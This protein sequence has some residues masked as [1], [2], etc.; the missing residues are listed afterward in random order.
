MEEQVKTFCGVCRHPSPG[1]EPGCPVETGEP[2]RGVNVWPFGINPQDMQP[3]GQVQGQ[4][5]QMGGGPGLA[6]PFCG[7]YGGQHQWAGSGTC[8][9]ASTHLSAYGQ[10]GPPFQGEL[11]IIWKTEKEELIRR[12]AE[13]ERRVDGLEHNLK[14]LTRPLPK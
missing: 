1:H 11:T 12:I 3:M 9:G 5:G 6:C 10:D 8:P 2:V 13:C 7:G 4:A 14:I